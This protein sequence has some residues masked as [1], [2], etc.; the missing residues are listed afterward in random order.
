MVLTTV[1]SIVITLIIFLIWGFTSVA[2]SEADI[3]IVQNAIDKEFNI[4]L[5]LFLVPLAVI[6]MIIKKVPALPALFIGALLG[7][8]AAIIFQPEIVSKIANTQG[9][10]IKTYYMGVMRAMY[11]SIRVTTENAMVNE[12]LTTRGMSGMLNTIWLIICAMVFGGIMEVSGM[13]ERITEAIIRT[14]TSTGG[15]IASTVGTC[16][17]FNITA[18]DQYLAIVV[19]GRMYAATFRNRGLKPEN[20]SRALE[21]SGTVT[22]VLVPWN[23]C[24]ATQASVLGVATLVYAPFCF[25]CIISPLMSM[26]FGFLNIKIARI[27]AEE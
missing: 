24:G 10:T 25:F 15:L 14:I 9:S 27:K 19:P 16:I 13:L 23:T 2:A 18:S 6:T 12:L 8:I 26:L 22:S 7:G 17:F 1:P 21:D 20:L 4:S 11:G 3:S 5:W